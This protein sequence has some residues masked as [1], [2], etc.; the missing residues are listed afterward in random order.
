MTKQPILHNIRVLDFTWVL[1]GPYTTRLLADF[2]AEV[3]KVQPLLSTETD[4][5]FSRCYYDTWNR[6]K[7]GVTL[8]L[9]KPEGIELAK[10]IVGVCDV[11]AE[12]FAPRVMT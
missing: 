11:V 8:N 12:S 9:D 6:N 10:R 5:A 1:A 4:D 2:G 7:L 3:I